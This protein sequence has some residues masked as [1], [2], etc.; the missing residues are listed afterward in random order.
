M[1]DA[2]ALFEAIAADDADRAKSLAAE[3]PEWILETDDSGTTP[4][5]KAG[6]EGRAE[7]A[8]ALLEHAGD[9]IFVAAAKGDRDRA[10]EIL[11]ADA[12][13]AMARTPDGFTPLHVAALFGDER[14]SD[15]LMEYGADI[16][17]EAEHPSRM[18]PIHC[19]ALSGRM[20]PIDLLL[21]RG[22]D[23]D[24][25]RA[26]GWTPLMIA[27]ACGFERSLMTLLH[28]NCD[29]DIESTD[30]KTAR[31]LATENGHENL[32]GLIPD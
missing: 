27:A 28:H 32:A 12:A 3:H 25:Q 17:V 21:S 8:T 13:N 4:V 30:G 10:Q 24:A 5:L 29:V 11:D 1:T 18:L 16:T 14:L 2:R 15:L 20:E 9:S 19:A 23:P 26:D 22:D 6:I 7:I 31:D